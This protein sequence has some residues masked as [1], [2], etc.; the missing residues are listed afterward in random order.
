MIL[1][2]VASLFTAPIWTATLLRGVARLS[3]SGRGNENVNT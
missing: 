1:S 2:R 3:R